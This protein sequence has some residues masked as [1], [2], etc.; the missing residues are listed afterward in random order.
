MSKVTV[1]PPAI[2]RLSF[3]PLSVTGPANRIGLLFTVALEVLPNVTLLLVRIKSLTKVIVLDA[4]SVPPIIDKPPGRLGKPATI[5]VPA[6]IVVAFKPF[7]VIATVG[8][9][10]RVP[11]LATMTGRFALAKAF[12][13]VIV[14]AVV[15]IALTEAFPWPTVGSASTRGLDICH[16]RGRRRAARD[17]GGCQAVKRQGE[18]SAGNRADTGTADRNRLHF[19]GVAIGLHPQQVR[20]ATAA[21]HHAPVPLSVRLVVLLPI[22]PALYRSPTVAADVP[23]AMT[24]PPKIEAVESTRKP[25]LPITSVS[26]DGIVKVTPAFT[27]SELVDTLPV[28]VSELVVAIS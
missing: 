22:V 28:K 16:E 5:T 24:P 2:C 10:P 21:E 19:A 20:S 12:W 4:A 11:A 15:E 1:L 7:V 13:N 9:T 25:P 6:L 8:V 18:T 17:G 27:T 23:N 26:P 14:I 3:T